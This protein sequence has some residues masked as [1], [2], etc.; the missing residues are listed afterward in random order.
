MAKVWAVT[1]VKDEQDIIFH[2]ILHMAEEGVDG[3]IIA[4][5][6]STDTTRSELE[7]VERTLAGSPCKIMILD[8]TEKAYYQ[9]K[10]MTHLARL[11]ADGYGADW[12][13]PFD[14]D[15][16]WY[17][18]HGKVSDVISQADD[19]GA[20]ILHAPLFNHFPTALDPGE[21]IPFQSIIYRQKE[22]GA[23][24]KV[25]FKWTD[26]A[27]IAQGNHSVSGV[28]GDAMR[29][30]L[31]LRHFP[32]RS[33]NQFLSKVYNGSKA[34]AATNLPAD[35]GAHW[36]GYADIINKFGEQALRENV[37][38]RYFWFYSPLDNGLMLDPAPFRRWNK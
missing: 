1:M 36:R 16:L 22:R 7:R 10:K 9:S 4:D 8:D 30:I 19:Q 38:E 37:F 17:S 31:E 5:N 24:P 26:G 12:I 33:W 29:G 14:A 35:M 23:L 11:A 18:H 15:E 21:K 13:I 3:I 34:Y 28:Q 6:V 32:Y 2:S 27:V 20:T 25:A